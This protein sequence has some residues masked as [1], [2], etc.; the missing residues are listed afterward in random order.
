[1]K[2][3]LAINDAGAETN[4]PIG[5]PF[6]QFNEGTGPKQDNIIVRTKKGDRAV[7]VEFP[8]HGENKVSDFV[9]PVS[10]A[11]NEK[12]GSGAD[13][14]PIDESIKKRPPS[15]SD[16][17]ISGQF[18]KNLPEDE[19]RRTE[20]ERDMGLVASENETPERSTSYLAGV[21]YIK[22]L[23][24]N[25]EYER[26]LLETDQLVRMYQTDPKLHSMRGTLL[27][28]LGKL[29]LAL[30]SWKQALRFDPDNIRLKRFIERKELKQR[31]LASP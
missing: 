9:I 11:F 16:R 7:E 29:E 25:K 31:G 21:A 4:K 30:K 1:M 20:L 23:Y 28:R 22:Q 27:E 6:G 13:G 2:S 17:E 26:A 5:N 19:G 15:Y 14:S 18:P 24:G 8:N 3:V 12:K 10:P